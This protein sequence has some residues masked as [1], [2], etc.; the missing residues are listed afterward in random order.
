MK[1]FLENSIDNL[2]QTSA[3][4]IRQLKANNVKSYFDLINYFPN[5]YE[6]YALVSTIGKIQAG[7][8]VTVKGRAM[9]IKNQYTR[10]GYNVQKAVLDDGTARLDVI[11]YNQPYLLRVIKPD[12]FISVAGPVKKFLSLNTLQA[13]EYELVE[14]KDTP[15]VH[16]GRIVPVY[17]ERKGLS[18]R[19]IREKVFYLLKKLQRPENQLSI[20]HDMIPSKIITDNALITQSLA[21]LNIH[22]PGD[23]KLAKQARERLGFDEIFIIRISSR[24]VREE[25]SREKVRHPLQVSRFKAEIQSFINQLPFKLTK[26]QRRCFAQIITDMAKET[27]MNRLLQGDVGSGKT[28]VAAAA[29]YLTCLNGLKTLFMAPTEIL[30]NQHFE[31]LEELFGNNKTNR[32][33]PKIALYTGA[34]KPKKESVEKIDILVG[35]HALISRKAVFKNIGFIIVDEQHKFGVAQRAA[36]KEKGINPHLLTMTAT[37]IPRT[38]VLTLYGELDLSI[39]DEM[40]KGR[41]LTKTY[42]IGKE[43][44]KDAYNWIKEQIKKKQVQVF[45]ICPLIEQSQIETM[46]SVRAAKKEYHFLVNQVFTDF[47]LGLLHGRMKSA[48]KDKI[49]KKFSSGQIDILVATPVVEVGI[50]IPNATIIL[51]ETADRF[52]LAQLHQL[53][54]RVGRGDKQSYCFLFTAKQDSQ[55][56]KRLKKFAQVDNGFE[57]AEYD[58]KVRGAGDIYGT[59]QHGV[60][61]LKIASLADFELIDKA[62]QAADFFLKK[63][64]LKDFPVLQKR[65]QNYRISVVSRD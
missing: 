50:D 8:K 2:P 9:E 63:Y 46:K 47:K 43:K 3:L 31:T 55:S 21:Y 7:E 39:I 18:S 1:D 12:S 29:S 54:G 35:T 4:T 60:A 27:A 40:P 30:A 24:L 41:P 25:W 23:L 20:R 56:L 42:L 36:L 28:V 17:P 45:V 13:E 19:T 48:D 34:K 58:L 5:R 62:H 10:R 11:W 26:A 59:K 53:R 16:T 32:S 49:M 52:G 15:T 65:V 44:R 22:F 37:P 14:N 33:L 57:L 6:N 61:D 51:I 64:R 38:V